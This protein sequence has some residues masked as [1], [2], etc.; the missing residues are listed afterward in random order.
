LSVGSAFLMHRPKG[1][2]VEITVRC[3][4]QQAIVR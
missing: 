3:R 2:V 4:N 1:V